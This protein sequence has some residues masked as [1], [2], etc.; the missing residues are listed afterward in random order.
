M[1]GI[2]VT[3][4]VSAGGGSIGATS[5]VTDSLGKAGSGW[6]RLGPTA[7]LNSVT[8]AVQATTPGSGYAGSP[9][10]FSA[11]ALAH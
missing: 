5:V 10:V 2:P 6:W 11:T 3:F 9:L 4:A 1:V 8:A 7:G